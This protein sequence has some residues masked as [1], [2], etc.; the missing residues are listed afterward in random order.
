MGS[1][2]SHV[3]HCFSYFT[4]DAQ[5][6]AYAS[7][8]HAPHHE[9]TDTYHAHQHTLH[10]HPPRSGE[11]DD[12]AVVLEA[13]RN[14]CGHLLGEIVARMDSLATEMQT[15]ERQILME[16]K[17]GREKGSVCLKLAKRHEIL[18]SETNKLRGHRIKIER[19]HNA[20]E[21]KVSSINQVEYGKR[22]GSLLERLEKMNFVQ[23]T[24]Q[25]AKDYFKLDTRNEYN[26]ERLADAAEVLG[27]FMNEYTEEEEAP[28]ENVYQDS[29]IRRLQDNLQSEL[30]Q[31]LDEAPAPA[32][33]P[34]QENTIDP[35]QQDLALL[36]V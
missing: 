27:E 34:I 26:A 25:T 8:Y 24:H 7:I 5:L 19:I 13:T 23:G 14:E 29:L 3:K 22:V 12:Q 17:Q 33:R 4:N 15:I 16:I 20:I 35:V 31:V 2:Q 36:D 21:S 30:T 18:A 6:P 11:A 32:K 1:L 10:G 28:E 9:H